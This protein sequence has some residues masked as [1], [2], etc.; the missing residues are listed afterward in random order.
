VDEML[1]ADPGLWRWDLTTRAGFVV[2][3][4]AYA[5]VVTRGDGVRYRRRLF[6]LRSGS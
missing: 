2:A 6:V 4:G 1:P 3:N 5:L